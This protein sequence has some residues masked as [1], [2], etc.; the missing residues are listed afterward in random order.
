MVEGLIYFVKTPTEQNKKKNVNQ[1]RN[2]QFPSHGGN[3][4]SQAESAKRSIATTKCGA[5]SNLQMDMVPATQSVNEVEDQIE[6]IAD[7]MRLV[8]NAAEEEEFQSAEE[9]VTNYSEDEEQSDI[10]Q[11]PG[12]YDSE[13]DNDDHSEL[14]TGNVIEANDKEEEMKSEQEA[15][16][17]LVENPHLGNLFKKMIKQGIEE[18]EQSS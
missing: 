8:M 15:M 6:L 18:H 17:L 3:V 11:K 7:G 2:V 10:D 14:E 1:N 13:N 5:E 4:S 16:R 12:E 9:T